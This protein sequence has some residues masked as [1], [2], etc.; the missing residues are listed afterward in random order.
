MSASKP[1]RLVDELLCGQEVAQCR[2][3]SLEQMLQSARRRQRQRQIGR[4]ACS[5]ALPALVIFGFLAHPLL[6]RPGSL[7]HVPAPVSAGLPADAGQTKSTQ[8]G[9]ALVNFV[10]DDELLNLFP[11]RAVALIGVPGEQQLVFLGSARPLQDEEPT[12]M[13]P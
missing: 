1:N 6:R 7:T 9:N 4:I 5:A 12:A 13:A 3:S 10:S 2:A 11:G 8:G